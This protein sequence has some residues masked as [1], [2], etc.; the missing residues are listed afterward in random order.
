M[1][2]EDVRCLVAD[3]AKNAARNDVAILKWLV[4]AITTKPVGSSYVLKIKEALFM[5]LIALSMHPSIGAF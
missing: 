2:P 3:L 1:K 5:P 4:H